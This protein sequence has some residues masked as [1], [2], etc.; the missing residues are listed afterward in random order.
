MIGPFNQKNKKQ[1]LP[2]EKVAE[3]K[4][5]EKILKDFLKKEKRLKKE[6]DEKIREKKDLE[7]K[8][9]SLE[10]KI[11]SIRAEKKKVEREESKA[12]DVNKKQEAEKKRWEIED[13]RK[14]IED[15]L[16]ETEEKVRQKNKEIKEKEEEITNSIRPKI[17][18]TSLQI[19]NINTFTS[20]MKKEEEL[21]NSALESYRS[22]DTER[23]AEL[24]SEVLR[25]NPEKDEAESF[26][27]KINIYK[28]ALN[29]YSLRNY[30]EALEKFE[31][32]LKM[33]PNHEAAK[34]TYNQVKNILKEE[35]EEGTEGETEKEER[36][37]EDFV[38]KEEETGEPRNREEVEKEIT[39]QKETEP[40]KAKQTAKKELSKILHKKESLKE[41]KAQA[42][43][44]KA[45]EEEALRAVLEKKRIPEK[46]KEKLKEDLKKIKK[47]EDRKRIEEE[48]KKLEGKIKEV[49]KEEK[50]AWRKWSEEIAEIE[51]RFKD[52]ERVYKDLTER[53]RFLAEV[54]EEIE[55]GKEEE[56][57]EEKKRLFK[58]PKFVFGY[59]TLGVDISDRSLEIIRLNKK[60]KISA[61]GRSA[62]EK[63][64]VEG[65]K[66]LD[67]EK[68]GEVIKNTLKKASPYPIEPKKGEDVKAIINLPESKV[69]VRKFE[70]PSSLSNNELLRRVKEEGEKI[71]PIDPDN[72]YWDYFILSTKEE[73]KEILYVGT[74]KEVVDGY[75]EALE[76]AGVEAMVVDI[77][78]I[79]L[80]RA[81]LPEKSKGGKM[82]VDIGSRVTNIGVFDT[83]NKFAFSAVVPFGGEYLTESIALNGGIKR[84][85]AEKI[86]RNTGLKGEKENPK[87]VSVIRAEMQFVLKKIK[88]SMEDYKKKYGEEVGEIFLAG[89]SSLIP[90]IAE[91]LELMTG[92]AVKAGN[93]LQKIKGA[94][95]IDG[96]VPGVLFS[97]VIGLALRDLQKDPVEGEINLLPFSM[98]R[99]QLKDRQE[100]QSSVRMFSVAIAVLGII[101]LIL[102]L[103]ST[104]VISF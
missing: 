76:K 59:L 51:E 32:F 19:K 16:W 36:E 80:A 89:G 64:I 70:V 101:A 67:A 61:F 45:K 40:E 97:N 58:L 99:K 38:E 93:S 43:E 28:E 94:D 84:D 60:G 50:K 8:L 104:E 56:D 82:L 34:E 37:F 27:E 41:E 10:K 103:W 95:K 33:E 63:G 9:S 29:A 46:E 73:K 66:V 96:N 39:E 14:S 85:L 6:R 68:L 5:K 11:S 88:D 102:V 35:G 15:T 75:L 100:Q 65:G 30:K 98:K 69:F 22:G 78:P 31:N 23:A 81:L 49:E 20:K 21:F 90:G 3:K 18:E 53:E 77:E 91:Y 12:E 4:E 79:S 92:K 13:K 52:M 26:L 17:K 71:I 1:N 48:N 62:L 2:K 57:Q 24:F 47:A 25:M 7:E 87:A 54:V 86:K 55:N 83:E 44:E 72:L 74:F 42:Y